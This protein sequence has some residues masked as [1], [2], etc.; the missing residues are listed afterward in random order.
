MWIKK[1]D[2]GTYLFVGG[3]K[4]K[5]KGRKKSVVS[6]RKSMIV[7]PASLRGQ[8][9]TGYREQKEGLVFTLTLYVRAISFKRLIKA[10]KLSVI[11]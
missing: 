3:N 1:V 9:D 11:R 4:P 10:Y 5:P 2:T 6:E 7:G 8:E